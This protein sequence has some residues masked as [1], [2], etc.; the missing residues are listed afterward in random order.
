MAHAPLENE[1]AKS[2]LCLVVVRW[3]T[4]STHAGEVFV[5]VFL[6]AFLEGFEFLG[7]LRMNDGEPEKGFPEFL[8]FPE[9]F[10]RS[11]FSGKPVMIVLFEERGVELFV[12]A[13]KPRA[14]FQA[15]R[16]LLFGEGRGI[17]EVSELPEGMGPAGS[18]SPEDILVCPVVVGDGYLP[19][20]H[21]AIRFS[22]ELFG[23]SLPPG[24]SE[25]KK[26]LAGLVDSGLEP[27]VVS[28]LFF[29][30]IPGG[31]VVVNDRFPLETLL[32]GRVF[33]NHFHLFSL[34]H[35][36]YLSVGEGNPRHIPEE[37]P[38]LRVRLVLNDG[39]VAYESPDIGSEGNRLFCNRNS[40]LSFLTARTVSR[41]DGVFGDTTEKLLDFP[42]GRHVLGEPFHR[43]PFREI[44]GAI[45][46]CRERMGY[47]LGHVPFFR[48]LPPVGKRG[49]FLGG[50]NIRRGFG[51]RDMG[52]SGTGASRRRIFILAFVLSECHSFEFVDAKPEGFVLF[53]EEDD[54]FVSE[55]EFPFEL[56]D[57]RPKRFDCLFL[58]GVFVHRLEIVPFGTE[59]L[60]EFAQG[61]FG[62]FRHASMRTDRIPKQSRFQAET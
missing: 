14:H 17:F 26:H 10:F 61:F 31:L 2:P 60:H 56:G 50:R 37:L 19:A 13:G 8:L 6:Q 36:G 48:G 58:L 18:P 5:F 16:H 51:V 9:H 62:V 11:P 25:R 52:A 29:C 54:R 20:G 33:R 15:A 46:A 53:P 1:V 59:F 12:E 22:P 21:R 3:D 38:D 40:R 43:F 35:T 55:T 41:F 49:T 39:C 47:R 27:S 24:L 45:R 23:I 32:D 4:R 57:S 7:I 42:K 34:E 30:H 44:A 28:L